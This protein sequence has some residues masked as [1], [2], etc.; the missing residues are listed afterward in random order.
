MLYSSKD[1]DK[2]KNEE[3]DRLRR[4]ERRKREALKK[5]DLTKHLVAAFVGFLGR[6]S[7]ADTSEDNR[8]KD[9]V[10]TAKSALTTAFELPEDDSLEVPRHIEVT[11]FRDAKH[12]VKLNTEEEEV[13]IKQEAEDEQED[14]DGNWKRKGKTGEDDEDEFGGQ[15]DEHEA[16]YDEDAGNNGEDNVEE[17]NIDQYENDEANMN[18]IVDDSNQDTDLLVNV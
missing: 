15:D 13:K 17:A 1:T 18:S 6:Q 12:D 16:N 9:L 3:R 10:E 5:E 4:E 14:D 2:K 11:F 7:E 8:F